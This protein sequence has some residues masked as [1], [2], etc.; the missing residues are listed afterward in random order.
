MTT[1]YRLAIYPRLC[2]HFGRELW[3]S[4]SLYKYWVDFRRTGI[5]SFVE[6]CHLVYDIQSSDLNWATEDLRSVLLVDTEDLSL[7]KRC[8]Q[9]RI[10]RIAAV[11]K[12]I[13]EL[14]GN[15]PNN[16]NPYIWPY[17]QILLLLNVANSPKTHWRYAIAATRCLRTLVRKDKPPS[18]DHLKCFIE[19]I[20]D[21]HPTIVR[22]LFLSNRY[23]FQT[24]ASL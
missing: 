14:V 11:D 17:F 19:Q 20:Y 7:V 23:L 21:D 2:Q 13:D 1:K 24:K 15:P 4:S 18:V 8:R 10:E 16:H 3:V 22:L 9:K 5:N 12:S 6:P